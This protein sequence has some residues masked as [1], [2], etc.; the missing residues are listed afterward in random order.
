[1]PDPV[2]QFLSI[3]VFFQNKCKK[4]FAQWKIYLSLQSKTNTK[5]EIMT[6]ISEQPRSVELT[7]DESEYILY[8]FLDHF[9]N[10][11]GKWPDELT[12]REKYE[13]RDR[14]NL[15][16]KIKKMYHHE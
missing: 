3:G 13:S 8:L 15:F 9:K 11:H 7:K 14:L 12:G 4:Y 6:Q 10:W 2:K 16:E 1:M 5:T